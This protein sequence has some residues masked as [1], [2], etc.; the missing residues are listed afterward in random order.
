MN[1]YPESMRGELDHAAM[2]RSVLAANESI[3][4][5]ARSVYG[6]QLTDDQCVDRVI[7]ARWPDSSERDAYA[8]AAAHYE[9][10]VSA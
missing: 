6:D 9:V 3:Q 10:E 2:I 1:H 7:A 8:L 5:E 4:A